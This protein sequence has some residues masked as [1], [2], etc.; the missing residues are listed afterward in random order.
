MTINIKKTLGALLID[1]NF[2]YK[3]HFYERSESAQ[4]F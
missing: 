2:T 3:I 4:L 1:P